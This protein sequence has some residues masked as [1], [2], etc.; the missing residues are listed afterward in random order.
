MFYGYIFFII[1][2][3]SCRVLDVQLLKMLLLFHYIV[4]STKYDLEPLN[5]FKRKKISL[6]NNNKIV[7]ES[8]LD[9]LTAY[10]INKKVLHCEEPH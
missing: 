1:F 8:F 5:I 9:Y 3:V 10:N 2:L 4:Q 6:Y 7:Q